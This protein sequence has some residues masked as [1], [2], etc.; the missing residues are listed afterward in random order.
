MHEVLALFGGE[1]V[2]SREFKPYNPLG[3][4]ETEA[5]RQVVDSGILSQFLGTWDPDFFGGPQVQGFERDCEEFFGVKHAIS[6]NS[7]TSGLIASVGAI[8]IEPGDEVI[9]TPWTM[10]ATATAVVHWNGLPVFVDIEPETFSLDPEKIEAAITP[11][12]RAIISVDIF[13][14]PANVEPLMEIAGRYNL[15]VLSDTAQSPGAHDNGRLA[16]TLTDIGGFSLNYHKH[17]HTGEGGVVVTND[18]NLAERVQL[19]RNH[20]E[21]VVAGK[22]VKDIRNMIGY[23]FRLGEIEA[24]IGRVQLKKLPSIVAERRRL[25]D[26][27]TESLQGLAGLTTPN[28]RTGVEHV[29]YVFPLTVDAGA[30]GIDRELIVSALEAEG[31]SGL[32]NGYANIHRLPMYEQRIA[33]GSSGFPWNAAFSRSDIQ[34]GLGTCPVAEE[35]HDRTFIGFEMC[36]HDL[37]D[38]DIDLIAEA[39]HKVWRHL[40]ALR[41]F[42]GL[43][44]SS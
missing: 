20:A 5:A 11:K 6:V 23:N 16:G 25:A 2:I 38:A 41:G 39:F 37:L 24:A 18:A 19:I 36:R 30:L 35:L 28:V 33:F 4:E 26:R 1:K 29:Y 7:W 3:P 31:V 21:A 12:T 13:G 40:E 42:S 32:M 34:Y 9:V 22:G 43:A 27:L 17:I 15:K 14:H 8:G 10:C 44:E